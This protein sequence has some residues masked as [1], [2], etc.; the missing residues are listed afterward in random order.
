M[1]P[2]R[3]KLLQTDAE[4]VDLFRS[5]FSVEVKIERVIFDTRTLDQIHD[6]YHGPQT[7]VIDRD[8]RHGLPVL[9]L[10]GVGMDDRRGMVLA[11]DLGEVRAW[12]FVP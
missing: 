7:R 1:S 4:I 2:N 9:V 11:I 5:L 10:D 12:T 8:V 3:A 6:L